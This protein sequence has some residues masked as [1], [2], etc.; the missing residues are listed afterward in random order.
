MKTALIILEAT[1]LSF[2]VA[3]L[4]EHIPW[5]WWNAVPPFYHFT[6][7]S[8]LVATLCIGAHELRKSTK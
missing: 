1:G 6:T 4:S 5:D 2:L 7:L 8:A 3:K